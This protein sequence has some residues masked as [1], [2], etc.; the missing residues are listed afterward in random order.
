MRSTHKTNQLPD[1]DEA[2]RNSLS[3]FIAVFD[4]TIVN[5]A[6][7]CGR[8]PIGKPGISDLARTVELAIT[9]QIGYSMHP[10]IVCYALRLC[11]GYYIESLD[12]TGS[13]TLFRAQHEL[14]DNAYNLILKLGG[15]YHTEEFLILE[16]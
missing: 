6:R 2:T 15:H 1:L 12:G 14:L 9:E 3:P 8:R 11:C 7:R 16:L 10:A 5:K 13:V 4:E